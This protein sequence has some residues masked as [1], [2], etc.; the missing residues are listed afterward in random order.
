MQ[1]DLSPSTADMLRRVPLATRILLDVGCGRGELGAGFRQLSPTTRLLGI[2]PDPDAASAAAETMDEVAVVDVEE[3]SLPFEISGGIDCIVYR[4]ILHR[5]K[6]P[7][8]V[9]RRHAAALSPNGMMLI[10]VPNLGHWSFADRLLRGTWD[11]ER[12]GML[13]HSHLR[14]FSLEG[15]RLGLIEAGLTLCDVQPHR[16][17]TDRA[18]TFAAALAPGL[19]ALGIDQDSFARRTAPQS[20]IWRVRKEARQRLTIAGT[21]MAPVGGVSHVRVVHPLQALATDPLVT[22]LVTDRVDLPVA[23][24]D[25]P[26]IFVL[27]RPALSDANGR[28]ILRLLIDSGWLVVTEFDDNPEFLADMQQGGELSFQGVHALQVSTPA[29][30]DVLRRHNPEVAVFPNA[31]YSLQPA[32]NFA[33]PRALTFFF[34]ALNRERDWRDLM[35]AINAVAAKAGERLK[36][37]VVHDQ[38]FFDA[39]ET[40]HKTFTPTC[41]YDTYLSI[42][43]RSEISFMPLA[44]NAFNR[45]KSDLK[46]VEAGACRVASLASRTVYEASIVDGQT[47]LLFRD[48]NELQA[49]LLRL[50]AMPELGC[51]IGDNARAYVANERMMAYQ[52]ASR[53]AWYRSLWARREALTEAL[54]TRMASALQPAA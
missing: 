5:L 14:W 36:F 28:R 3:D 32:R 45:A 4:D 48:A 38:G 46:F 18:Q 21:M 44:D 41:D 15:M 54:R 7:W 2:E 52:V 9:I 35:P 49:K 11:H 16:T 29:L 42:L 34:A 47:G 33:D 6:D 53:L 12:D 50:V 13:D 37:Q 27:H 10:A 24:D 43:S 31:M 1:S 51:T 25:T 26:H 20:Y 8:T 40:P 23:T 17:D 30:A 39:L 22:A 19:A